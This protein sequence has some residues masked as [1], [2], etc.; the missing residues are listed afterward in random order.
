MNSSAFSCA[1]RSL[2]AQ[3]LGTV[4]QQ[5][6]RLQDFRVAIDRGENAGNLVTGHA[7]R[8]CLADN[9]RVGAG[10]TPPCAVGLDL[11]RGL[12]GQLGETM[13]HVGALRLAGGVHTPWIEWLLFPVT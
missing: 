1:E 5:A 11:I 12:A 6:L 8:E 9:V 10:Q 4:H 7:K 2:L 13:V 3:L